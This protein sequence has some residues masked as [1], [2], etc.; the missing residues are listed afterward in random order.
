[1]N[2]NS[3]Q[4]LKPASHGGPEFRSVLPRWEGGHGG[5]RA[6]GPAWGPAPPAAPQTRRGRNRRGFSSGPHS[7]LRD[8]EGW[9]PSGHR[10]VEVE[11]CP[12]PELWRCLGTGCWDP[13]CQNAVWCFVWRDQCQEGGRELL[14]HPWVT[15][16]CAD[17]RRGLPH[18]ACTQCSLLFGG[19]MYIHIQ[20]LK[21]RAE[22]SLPSSA[23]VFFGASGCGYVEGRD[24][25][26][27]E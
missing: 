8:E 22:P 9:L 16:F 15:S 3:R 5:G 21:P 13:G 1:M 14:W 18:E 24:C 27:K 11:V 23:C 6:S 20:S 4:K 26:R 7:R 10:V 25:K 19:N 17:G 12:R 2:P